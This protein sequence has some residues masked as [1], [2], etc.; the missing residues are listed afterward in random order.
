MRII[1][2]WEPLKAIK[3]FRSKTVVAATAALG[4]PIAAC[5]AHRCKRHED[6]KVLNTTTEEA[7]ECGGCVAEDITNL[8]TIYNDMRDRLDRACN[9]LDLLTPG[10][11]DPFRPH[12]IIEETEEPK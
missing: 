5:V 9:A 1:R 2:A 8:M 6:V 4:T 11:G 10:A 7:T 3:G 12:P